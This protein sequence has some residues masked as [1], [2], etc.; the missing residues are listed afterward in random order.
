M[1]YLERIW[2]GTCAATLRTI[3]TASTAQ[4]C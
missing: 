1:R 4:C 3:G 2:I